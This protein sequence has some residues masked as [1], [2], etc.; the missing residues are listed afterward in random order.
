[1]YPPQPERVPLLRQLRE[2]RPITRTL[3]A[4]SLSWN[5]ALERTAAPRGL[6]TQLRW[7]VLVAILAAFWPLYRL[8]PWPDV[9][10][11]SRTDIAFALI[12]LVGAGCA[13]SAAWM[14][15]FQRLAALVMMGGAGLV[16]C[17]TFVW[18][19]APDLALTQ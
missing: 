2:H 8:A 6:Q 15:K 17:V 18:F 13:I 12:W 11:A 10:A 4:V 5:R 7:L 3:E 1:R 19:S 16:T 14:A 9:A